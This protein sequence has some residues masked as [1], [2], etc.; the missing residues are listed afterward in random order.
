MTNAPMHPSE[1]EAVDQWLAAQQENLVESL[2]GVLDVEAG[3]C[4]V[5]VYAHHDDLAQDL[6]HTLDIEAGLAAILPATASTPATGDAVPLDTGAAINSEDH[7]QHIAALSPQRRLAL[8]HHPLVSASI[9]AALL[10]RALELS[11]D[12]AL[13]RARH[14]AFARTRDLVHYIDLDLARSLDSNFVRVLACA[15]DLD[16]NLGVARHRD[17]KLASYLGRAGDLAHALEVEL[18]GDLDR[19]LDVAPHGDFDLD[20]DLALAVAS[21]RA[22][23][24]GRLLAHVLIRGLD[25][26]VATDLV[27]GLGRD[28]V[29]DVDPDL[30]QIHGLDLLRDLARALVR[31]LDRAVRRL[32]LE[33]VDGAGLGTLYDLLD[34]FTQADLRT[35]D[36]TGINLE[37][38]RWSEY[39]TRWPPA[40]DI[41]RLRS[42]SQETRAGSGIYVVRPGAAATDLSWA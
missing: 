10:V 19:N 24:L 5:L 12:L 1:D 8:R 39:S 31:N 22:R 41:E 34:D 20:I 29:F 16:H 25:I 4:E 28:F 13:A 23:I 17:L 38:V 7:L 14:R 37:G 6:A 9:V 35:V 18:A 3:L 15:R 32:G 26:E 27:T 11:F 21:D 33:L 42:D 30:G 40:V 2:T 36:L